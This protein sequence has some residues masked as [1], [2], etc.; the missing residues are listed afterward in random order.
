MAKSAKHMLSA[1]FVAVLMAWFYS[2]AVNPVTGK[3]QLML[4][5]EGDEM[6]LGQQTDQEVIQSYGLYEDPQIAGY[7]EE[8][9]VKL[10]RLSH[11]PNLPYKFRL[12]NSPVIN[13]FAVPGGYVYITRGILTFLN[14]EAEFAGVVGHEIGHIAARHSAQQYSRAQLAQ[15][16]L[17]VASIF[18]ETFRRY[19]GIAEFGVGMM[20][21][22]FSRDME[23]Q[24]DELGVEYSTKAGYDAHRMAD[25]FSTLKKMTP[26]SQRGGL[27]GWFSTHPDPEE[28]EAKIISLTNDWQRKLPPRD[29]LVNHEVYLRR[30]DGIVFGENPREGFVK[31]GIFYHPDLRFQFPVPDNWQVNNTPRQVQLFTEKQD[32]VILF[33]LDEA[34]SPAQA[35]QT[36]IRKTKATVLLSEPS[37]VNGMPAYRVFS[38][39]TTSDATISILSYFIQK[40]NQIYVFHGYTLKNLFRT[41]EGA[42][43]RTMRGFANLTDPAILNIQPDRIR[44]RQVPRTASMKEILGSFGVEQDKIEK[45]ALINGKDPDSEVEANT[46]IK[47]VQK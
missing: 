13:A 22:K 43:N 15:L 19:S 25:F 32:A 46:L 10:A 28:R 31:E 21:L 9:G 17:G 38:E 5:S 1:L 12:L 40:E 2:C 23:R 37:R 27:P 45:L 8:L 41:Y 33:S 39:M 7:V 29:Y 34:T 30:I 24:A 26:E 42:F 3:R 16:G 35:A 11:R 44:I 20:F 14:S 6:K 18:S 36:F 4:L 47:L